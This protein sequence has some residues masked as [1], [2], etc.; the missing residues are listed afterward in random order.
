MR[1]RGLCYS[2][3][4]A[5]AHPH[6]CCGWAHEIS[7]RSH[8]CEQIG[9]FHFYF[10]LT[11]CPFFSRQGGKW[12]KSKICLV[13][14]IHICAE[15]STKKKHHLVRLAFRGI[16]VEVT[17][18][19]AW[20]INVLQCKVPH[21]SWELKWNRTLQP[22]SSRICRWIGFSLLSCLEIFSP[23]IPVSQMNIPGLASFGF[24]YPSRIVFS[25]LNK[26]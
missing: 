21:F 4:T 6:A 2:T 7:S 9:C 20:I 24:S 3:V 13:H 11:V 15:V 5:S 12:A 23:Q 18:P 25:H 14:E 8:K 19:F 17:V 26:G 16:W 1:K 10:H 22:H